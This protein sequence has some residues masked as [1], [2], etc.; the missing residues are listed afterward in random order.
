MTDLGALP[1]VDPLD[2]TLYCSQR[3]GRSI[4]WPPTQAFSAGTLTAARVVTPT[5]FILLD[6]AAPAWLQIMV[7]DINQAATLPRN[8]DSYGA[9]RLQ[10]KSAIR[11]IELLDR[12][13]FGGPA[14]W[15]APTKDGG[16]HMEWVRH[17]LGLEL[18]V[19][20]EGGVSVVLEQVGEITEWDTSEFGDERLREALR[21]VTLG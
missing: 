13:G 20:Q 12:M 4:Y 21:L 14:P 3:H 1:V 16:L 17:D 19:T 2:G 5:E 18:E 8:W 6:E 7:D 9:E 15:V 11:A 10:V